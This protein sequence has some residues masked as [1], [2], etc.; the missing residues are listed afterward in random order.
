MTARGIVQ[1]RRR[2]ASTRTPSDG[3]IPVVLTTVLVS[4]GLVIAMGSVRSSVVVLLFALACF[5][6][7]V[8]VLATD[9]FVMGTFALVAMPN[10]HLGPSPL[11]ANEAV[12]G[13]CLVVLAVSGRRIERRPPTWYVSAIGGLWLT[14]LASGVINGNYLQPDSI[15]RLLHVGLFAAVALAIPAGIIPYRPMIKGLVLGLV[16]ACAAGFV[17]LVAGIGTQGYTNRLSGLLF[18]E[19]NFAGFLLVAVVPICLAEFRRPRYRNA[20]IALS[21]LSIGL[22]FSR[23]TYLA[24]ALAGLWFLMGWRWKPGL[25]MVVL[26]AVFSASFLLIPA[27]AHVSGPF[28]QRLGSDR[29]R[30]RILDR[31]TRSIAQ[32]PILGH[33]PG[34]AT[35]LLPGQAPFKFY[36]HSS[37]YALVQEGGMVAMAIFGS[38]IV[39]VFV[40]LMRQGHERVPWL[41]ASIIGLAVC[42]ISLGEVLLEIGAAVVLGSLVRHLMAHPPPPRGRRDRMR[43]R[44]RWA[45]AAPAAPP[46]V[47]APVPV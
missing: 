12:L 32:A 41:E 33:G 44:R 6:M 17:S 45:P 7:A 16:L 20:L 36:F 30:A 23:T 8:G 21:I 24:L 31:E 29:L 40:K 46:P 13:F 10:L 35:V 15:K 5:A 9:A 27:D 38:L 11:P 19:P 1:N 18:G 28:A 34:T 42:A 14:L 25:A 22:T 26:V 3:T 39:G 37:Y 2:N 43:P 47:P 4:I